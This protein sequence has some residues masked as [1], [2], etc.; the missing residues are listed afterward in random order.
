M[1]QWRKLQ[2]VLDSD[3]EEDSQE[4]PILS[5]PACSEGISADQ[6]L[7]DAD[8][9]ATDQDEAFQEETGLSAYDTVLH[10]V[11]VKSKKFYV[12]VERKNVETLS[13]VV[14]ER[15]DD[16]SAT[17]S[18]QNP[19]V[20]HIGINEPLEDFSEDELQHNDIHLSGQQLNGE[21]VQAASD[22]A[23]EPPRELI[24]LSHNNSTYDVPSSPLTEPPLTPPIDLHRG[25]GEIPASRRSKSPPF[26]ES[27]DSSPSDHTRN[28]LDMN[29]VKSNTER[30]ATRP[31]RSLRQRNPIQLHPYALENQ[32]Y[33]QTFKA[34]G[35]KPVYLKPVEIEDNEEDSDAE[36]SSQSNRDDR[37]S[38]P[39]RKTPAS[40]HTRGQS[41]INQ[42]EAFLMLDE[43][44]DFPDVS[45]LLRR[46]PKGTV[47]R[48]AKRQ[49][50]QHTY[51]R[52]VRG[53]IEKLSS[54]N[55]SS[56][57]LRRQVQDRRD[58]EDIF[59]PP[60]SPPLSSN[61][62]P[63]VGQLSAPNVFRNSFALP[64]PQLPTPLLSSAPSKRSRQAKQNSMFPEEIFRDTSPG[65]GSL[66]QV[67]SSTEEQNQDGEETAVLNA[68]HHE[69]EDVTGGEGE[70]EAEEEIHHVQRKIRGV[71]PASWLRLDLKNQ[72]KVQ[73]KSK[74]AHRSDD[75]PSSNGSQRGIAR[76][77]ART[78]PRDSRSLEDS[79][80]QIEISGDSSDENDVRIT[81]SE[82]F[83]RQEF[84]REESYLDSTAAFPDIME[85]NSFD[86]MLPPKSRPIAT[87]KKTGAHQMKFKISKHTNRP[88]QDNSLFRR[89][90]GS[91]LNQPKITN[92]V[93]HQ[94]DLTDEEESLISPRLGILDAPI[95]TG[96]DTG[97]VPLFVRVAR[98]TARSR[99]DAGRHSP[100]RKHL[101]LATRHDTDDVQR[102]L[103]SWKTA[104]VGSSKL[105][106]TKKRHR[107]PLSAT[108]GNARTILSSHSRHGQENASLARHRTTKASFPQNLQALK[109][110]Q[111][112]LPLNQLCVR[113]EPEY[114]RAL[115]KGAQRGDHLQKTKQGR[116]TIVSS[117][118]TLN[119]QQPAL[120]EGQSESEFR[121]RAHRIQ[122][123]SLAGTLKEGSALNPLLERYLDTEAPAT[124]YD[125]Q[126]QEDLLENETPIAEATPLKPQC[127]RRKRSPR[128][129][130]TSIGVFEQDNEP[131][132]IHDDILEHSYSKRDKPTD[133]AANLTGLGPLGT[134]Y[135][136]FADVVPLPTGKH[137]EMDTFIGGGVFSA[138]LVK[139]YSELRVQRTTTHVQCRGET[140]EWGPWTE[141]V[142]SQLALACGRV[143]E[144]LQHLS[145]RNLLDQDSSSD[146]RE[147][148]YLQ[149][150]IIRYM[151]ESLSFL[152]PIDRGYFLQKLKSLIDKLVADISE[153]STDL[154]DDIP[155]PA[156]PDPAMERF[157]TQLSTRACVIINQLHRIARH[158]LID[159]Q[160]QAEIQSLLVKALDQAFNSIVLGGLAAIRGFLRDRSNLQP[161]SY[162]GL[163]KVESFIV[164]YH[165]AKQEPALVNC[166]WHTIQSLVVEESPRELRN[167]Q[168]LDRT[169]HGLFTLLPLSELDPEGALQVGKRYQEPLENWTIVKK[170]LDPVHEVY[171][172]NPRGQSS[173]FNAY[174]RAVSARCFYLIKHWG[175][176]RCDAIIGALFDFHAQNKLG[177]LQNEENHGSPTFLE[178]LQENTD[179]EIVQR[180]RSFHIFLKVIGMGLRG[181]RQVYPVKKIHNVAWRLMPNHGRTHP[182]DEDL[183]QED[184]DALRNH[185]DLLSTLYW[186]LLP[187]FRPQVRVIQNLVYLETSHRAACHISIRTWSNLVRYQ[188][189]TEE[190]IASLDPFKQWFDDFMAQI[191]R[192]HELART[193]VEAEARLAETRDYRVVTREI[194]ERII[195]QNQ[196]QIEALLSDALV[197]IARAIDEARSADVIKRLHTASVS[198][199]F[200]LFNPQ[201]PRSN[202]VIIQALD[203]VLNSCSKLFAPEAESESQ[204]F[205]DWSGFEDIIDPEASAKVI[206]AFQE[207]MLNP[208]N[209][210]MSDCFGAD[211]SLDDELLTKAVETWIAVGR[212]AIRLDIRTWSDYLSPYGHDSWKSLRDTEQTRRFTPFFLATLMM[213]DDGVYKEQKTAFLTSWVESLVERESLLKFQ[214]LLTEAILNTDRDNPLLANLP[215]WTDPV[216]GKFSIS[217]SEFRNR[218]LSLISSIL[219]NLRESL[220]F[221]VYHNLDEVSVLRAE[222]VEILKQLMT[223]MKHKYQEL[224]HGSNIQGAYVDF[225]HNVVSV[226]QQHTG[227]IFPVDRF[228][229]EPSTFPLPAKDPTYVVGRLRNYGLRLQDPKALK[230]L[231][232]FIQGISGQAVMNAQQPSLVNQLQE[233]LS[234]NFEDGEPRKISLRSFLM[235]AV[236][237]AYIE[238]AFNTSCGWL[239]LVPILEAVKLAFENIFQDVD[240]FCLGGMKSIAA[241]VGALIG[242]LHISTER[243]IDQPAS[244]KNPV[245]LKALRLAL[246]AVSGLLPMLDYLARLP[247]LSSSD[248]L[249]IASFGGML[250][251]IRNSLTGIYDDR[252]AVQND[253]RPQRPS[254]GRFTT[255]DLFTT[256]ELRRVLEK[257]W[258]WHDGRYYA[259]K[260]NTRIE[261]AAEIEDVEGERERLMEE[262]SQFL[263]ALKAY[264]GLSED[265]DDGRCSTRAFQL[266]IEEICY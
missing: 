21:L 131:M 45:V 87:T 71:L 132:L 225:V 28:H 128:R 54:A 183:S 14:A 108:S 254:D 7:I 214:H 174:H 77:T 146:T 120:L 47:Y 98:R 109:A 145:S 213:K 198:S 264:P 215:F 242:R 46:G 253:P 226:L 127:I 220:D 27:L 217:I 133:G 11:P 257:N 190:P 234:N 230:Q 134:I 153:F 84:S 235:Q 180:D 182:K 110:L 53:R 30:F 66:T 59:Q 251:T 166:F 115:T 196:R 157:I 248:V 29:Q 246:S 38:S 123:R 252:I 100:S 192:Q 61:S 60:P 201:Q 149:E 162:N 2:C 12:E 42:P 158:E 41:P 177:S 172:L 210:L 106:R 258:I 92:H 239:L 81:S 178:H 3:D 102:T 135:S 20:P 76:P 156:R 31:N 122:E 56:Q 227:D 75:V 221:R 23:T 151:A 155:H 118:R 40:H 126:Q 34:R 216:S 15:D 143:S 231:S 161:V 119:F 147:A 70:E 223:A 259:I 114:G 181:M 189:S 107:K 175:W 203:V 173:N 105:T 65:E 26:V 167:A 79:A 49:K 244:L 1:A 16:V 168:I 78:R 33:R 211:A 5:N 228:F 148:M 266:C 93:A 55:G 48:G 232:S 113:S 186:A 212:L 184:L 163:V 245:V 219:S 154:I 205:G 137:F 99:P 159:K 206:Q 86:L 165:I 144:I 139:S 185:H 224:G 73:S 193:E 129:L 169:W 36:E 265:D 8:G 176:Y 240:G 160:L 67:M 250:Y 138:A 9:A 90:R 207:T 238:L 69:E 124:W 200:T 218:R 233:A 262:L 204:D 22:E 37:N 35:L 236:F 19:E 103:Q 260:G 58:R 229:T 43:E 195:A 25:S 142:S 52:D 96:I 74:Y 64:S 197:S 261:V 202:A 13:K 209:R 6:G 88:K 39:V 72:A 57:N 94:I 85:D 18:S 208:I 24:A 187:A 97:D 150:S 117:V 101:R 247:L 83:L 191:V 4:A 171:K 141:L 32:I 50:I 10:D 237:P 152:D 95:L 104:A 112:P 170:L 255:M 179:L 256:S 140:Y 111:K 68:S 17:S 263:D 51:S 62:S 241:S 91:H 194:Q 63:R 222:Y 44:D 116:G 164:S 136:S 130:D 243:L 82:T 89:Q 125:Q 121:P 249:P 199:V 80:I 188:L